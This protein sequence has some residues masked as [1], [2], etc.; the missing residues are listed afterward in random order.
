MD[1]MEDV[2]FTYF[3]D[4]ATGNF[5][6]HIVIAFGCHAFIS[7]KIMAEQKTRLKSHCFDRTFLSTPN[8]LKA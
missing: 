1:E 8:I 2:I 6:I 4:A 5:V 7:H 3:P